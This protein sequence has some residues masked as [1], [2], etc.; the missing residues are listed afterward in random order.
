M[1]KGEEMR[2]RACKG[3]FDCDAHRTGG[4][5]VVFSIGCCN[6]SPGRSKF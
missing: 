5:S 4:A 3:D 2:E 6:G 1:M